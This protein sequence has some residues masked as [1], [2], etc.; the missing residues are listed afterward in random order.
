MVYTFYTFLKKL[1]IVFPLGMIHCQRVAGMLHLT[2][3]IPGTRS[4]C[5]RESAVGLHIFGGWLY[6]H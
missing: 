6:S 1:A 5:K 3:E 2:Q 4:E